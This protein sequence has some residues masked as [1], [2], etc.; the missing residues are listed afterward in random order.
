MTAVYGCEEKNTHSYNS[1]RINNIKCNNNLITVTNVDPITGSDL[2]L[3]SILMYPDN[4]EPHV[5]HIDSDTL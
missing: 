1:C 4:I 2:D 5:S 3:E